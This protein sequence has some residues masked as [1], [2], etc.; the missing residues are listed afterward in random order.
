M[1]RER[2]PWARS[3]ADGEIVALDWSRPGLRLAH[4]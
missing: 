1:G 4:T 2:R 3:C